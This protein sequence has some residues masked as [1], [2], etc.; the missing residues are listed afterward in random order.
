MDVESNSRDATALEAIAGNIGEA[1]ADYDEEVLPKLLEDNEE[2]EE[3]MYVAVFNY[4]SA[5]SDSDERYPKAYTKEQKR[6]LR[7]K[8]KRFVTDNK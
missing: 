8:A 2:E 3:A 5:T 6:G 4:L 1:T 7:R